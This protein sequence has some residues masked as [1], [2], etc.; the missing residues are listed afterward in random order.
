MIGWSKRE[1]VIGVYYIGGMSFY[2]GNQVKFL[3]IF[4][5]KEIGDFKLRVFF[6]DFYR[7]FLEFYLVQFSVQYCRGN[8]FEFVV[9]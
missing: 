5:G 4:L 3:I 2:L 9:F 1:L 7:I 6:S 8:D